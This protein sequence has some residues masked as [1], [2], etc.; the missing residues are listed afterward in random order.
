MPTLCCLAPLAPADASAL[1]RLYTEPGVRAFLGGVVAPAEARR[2][3]EALLGGREPG[4][5]WAI[6]LGDANAGGL[7]GIVSLDPHHD[8]TDVQISYLL[9]PEHQG[10]GYASHAVG[11]ALRYAAT[12]PGFIRVVAETRSDNARSLRLLERVGM[13]FERTVVRFGAEQCIYATPALPTSPP[14]NDPLPPESPGAPATSRH[15]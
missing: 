4:Q 15:P 1:L 13:R 9:L 11:A 10:R 6:R 3:V 7:L 2:R 5:V 8:G 14:A 12:V